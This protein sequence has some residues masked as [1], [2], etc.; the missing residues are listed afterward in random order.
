MDMAVNKR[1]IL[2]WIVVLCIMMPMIVPVLAYAQTGDGV[3]SVNEQEYTMSVSPEINELGL[4]VSAK[5]ITSAF[6]LEYDFDSENKAF[7]IYDDKHGKI[8]LMHNATTFYSGENIYE[9]N[10]YFYVKNGEPFVEVGFFCN[11][12]SSS[13]EYMREE[14]RIVIYKDRISDKVAKLD[15]NGVVTP[16]YLEPVRTE[17]GLNARVE[18]L[19]KCFDVE[20]SYDELT[21]TAILRNENGEEI[22]L[23]DGAS[24]FK[25]SYGEFDCGAFFNIIN[26]I[27]MIEVGFFCD[28][29]GASYEYNDETKTL[30]IFE[31]T[32]MTE[33]NNEESL[34]LLG[35]DSTV[36]G[37]VKYPVGAPKGGL[38]V[39][40]VLQ[41]T[42]SRYVMYKGYTYYTGNNYIL[43][44]VEFDEGETSNYYSY[45][46]SDYYTSTY[47]SY[48]LYYEET[49]HE[50]YGY[51]NK[52]GATTSISYSPLNSSTYNYSAKQ[53]NYSNNPTVNFLVGSNYISGIMNLED[54]Q[55]APTGGIDVD[56]ILQTRTGTYTNI[57]GKGSYYNIGNNNQIGT[58][59]IPSGCN[60]A[61]YK[62]DISDCF[63][64]ASTYCYYSLFYSAEDNE[65]V[66][67]YGYYNNYGTITTT[68]N[69]PSSGSCYYTTAKVFDFM[70]CENVDLTLPIQDGYLP[71]VDMVKSPIA[72][73]ESGH[74]DVGE[75]VRLSTLTSDADIYY[76]TDGSTPTVYSKKYSG[77]I[78]IDKDTVI[79]AI[80]VKSDMRD[81][82]VATYTY[83]V[84]NEDDVYKFI[85]GDTDAIINGEI[86][87]MDVAPVIINGDIY[88][89]IRILGESVGACVEW[90]YEL[91]Q[92]TFVVDGNEITFTVG[93]GDCYIV[94]SRTVVCVKT[95]FEELL[96][97]KYVLEYSPISITARDDGTDESLPTVEI[98]SV[99][100]RSGEEVTVDVSIT[101]NVGIAGFAIEVQ[102]DNTVLTPVSAIKGDVLTSSVLS[103]IDQGGDMT[104]YTSVYTQWS[105]PSN[106]MDDG[107]LY[108]LTFKINDDAEECII[109]LT[110][111]YVK[112]DIA[113]QNYETVLINA[114]NGQVEV[115][116]VI[117]GDIFSDDSVNS[118]DAIK[119][120][121]HL[122]RWTI[123]LTDREKKAADVFSDNSINSKDAIKLSQYLARWNITLD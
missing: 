3:I 50:E 103:N 119:L 94:D 27:P 31:D 65:C 105:N 15:F 9:C 112:D 91:Q 10:P 2:S 40:L 44:T 33:K 47:T 19:S 38:S 83:I 8:I 123:T 114:K 57:Y 56:L 34:E 92:V 117:K 1:K 122:A 17:Y 85:V 21:K 110:L 14:N 76:T 104:Q 100:G 68:N 71:N 26:G 79:K 113:N 107:V 63:T 61:T 11:M 22:E 66:V 52:Y 18:D 69:I 101:N 42:G 73:I 97:E 24:T 58:I 6:S 49:E 121:Q 48:A 46:V 32:T 102:Y 23:I 16:L 30:T 87:A 5:D 84:D 81:S 55:V 98:D 43:G 29:Y 54:G 78:L 115:V 13:Y 108:T 106:V 75:R 25:S 60:S 59:T 74:V 37:H 41:Q 93:D 82:E 7:E 99:V 72:N 67:P 88:A 20:Y 86:V 35:Y 120:S 96:G 95:L 39:K 51:C 4:M 28:L 12:F 64:D 90:D 118:K 36:S 45:D 53:F 89:P 109:P 77:S 116:N 62:F 80:A 111:N 70:S